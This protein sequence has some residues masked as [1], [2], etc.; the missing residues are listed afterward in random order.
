MLRLLN[1]DEAR[2]TVLRRGTPATALSEYMN[3]ASMVSRSGSAN[4]SPALKVLSKTARVR[5]FRILMRTRVWP[6][7]AVGVEISTSRQ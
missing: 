4:F 6:P 1:A 5:R 7:R 2:E 3:E